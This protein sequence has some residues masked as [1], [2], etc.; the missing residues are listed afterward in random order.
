MTLDNL[1]TP[2]ERRR[3]IEYGSDGTKA[4]RHWYDVQHVIGSIY[5]SKDTLS[6]QGEAE[7]KL[8][9]FFN[10]KDDGMQFQ[11]MSHPERYTVEQIAEYMRRCKV[12]SAT[13]MYSDLNDRMKH[14]KFIGNV[15]IEFFASLT[16]PLLIVIPSTARSFL[17]AGRKK[18][19]RRL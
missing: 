19:V 18:S 12:D 17:P 16:Q 3:V 7:F 2:F 4:V 10:D 6:D 1:F 14:N 13:Q 5:K 9:V 15:Q 11:W 8:F